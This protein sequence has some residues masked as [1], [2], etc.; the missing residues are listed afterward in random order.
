MNNG[1]K[2]Y[3]EEFKRNAV[4]M[5]RDHGYRKTEAAR[6]LGV[7]RSQLDRWQRQFEAER[8]SGEDGHAPDPRDTELR[9]LRDENRRL[10]EE[11]TILK[12]AAAFF[13]NE[14]S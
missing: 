13:A 6:R 5:I 7:D 10:Q 12:K 4:A 3:S 1:R 8:A 11:R 2:R 14:L 9:R